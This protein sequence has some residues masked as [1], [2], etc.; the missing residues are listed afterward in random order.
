MNDSRI[1]YFLVIV[2]GLTF[3][4]G[5]FTFYFAEGISYFANDPAACVNCHVMRSQY[6]GWLRS[7]HHAV[8]VCND[9]HSTDD[10]IGKYEVKLINGFNH[11]YA[12][13]T[14]WFKEPIMITSRNRQVTEAACLKCHFRMT[15]A[16]RCTMPTGE[17]S[18]LRCHRS[19]GHLH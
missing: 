5:I 8:A 14:G 11:S 2:I 3:G 1:R 6:E 10:L 19:V 17:Q 16:I 4:L 15:E 12:F 7:S 9:C 13:T 18:C